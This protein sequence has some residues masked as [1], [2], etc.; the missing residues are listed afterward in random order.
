MSAKQQ[1]RVVRAKDFDLSKVTFTEVRTQKH[2]GKSI[3]MNYDDHSI[4]L[5]T[6]ELHLPFDSGEYYPN[7]RG[8][9]KYT[10]YSQMTGHDSDPTM[11]E[12]LSKMEGLDQMLKEAA[13]EHSVPWFKKKTMT[14]DAVESVFT[15]MVKH[16]KDKETGE[17]NGKFPPGFKFKIKRD[18][19]GQVKCSCFK[20][21]ESEYSQMNVND[22]EKDEHVV[23][24]IH[25]PDSEKMTKKHEGIFKKG[26][27]VK[28]VLRCDGIW[29]TNGN[30]G[31]T[32]S[33][34]QIR[35]KSPPGFNDY[36]FLEDTDDED[37]RG[38]T[39]EGNFVESSS[40][41]DDAGNELTRTST[42]KA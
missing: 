34:E 30:F 23:L 19:D 36:A 26:T 13:M 18:D 38:E 3:W 14:M 42:K 10:I 33:A 37:D 5:Q 39:L 8:G 28:M 9:G 22:P 40:D 25:I 7:D 15:P 32:W 11:M 17:L 31:C 20:F 35:I 29:I 4:F 16:S 1:S 6:P 27:K 2:G 41:E 12:F 21:K 24:G